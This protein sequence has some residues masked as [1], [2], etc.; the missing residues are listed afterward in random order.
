M[1]I[2]NLGKSIRKVSIVKPG[3]SGVVVIHRGKRS[4]KKKQSWE[5]RPFERVSR[6][7]ADAN[8]ASAKSYAKQHRKSNRKKRD[9]WL[10][11]MPDNMMRAGSKGLKEL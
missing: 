7:F 11:D 10:R 4:R 5:L 9:G 1:Q 8:L 2:L 6:R 3:G